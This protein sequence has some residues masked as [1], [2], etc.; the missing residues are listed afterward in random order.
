MSQ[1]RREF[2]YNL[3]GLFV[4]G[5][6]LYDKLGSRAIFGT[7]KTITPE[8]KGTPLSDLSPSSKNHQIS[9]I[10]DI[11]NIAMRWE[12]L[13]DTMML[14]TFE[15]PTESLEETAR[16]FVRNPLRV[17]DDSVDKTIV[18]NLS[19]DFEKIFTTNNLQN[20]TPYPTTKKILRSGP[21]GEFCTDEQKNIECI[22]KDKGSVTKQEK[23][24]PDFTPRGRRPVTVMKDDRKLPQELELIPEIVRFVQSLE[25]KRDYKRDGMLL[26]YSQYPS[27]TLY[28]GIGDCED[29][30]ILLA[31]FLENLQTVDIRTALAFPPGHAATLAAIPDLPNSKKYTEYTTIEG[32]PYT[33]LETT[34]TSEIYGTPDSFDSIESLFVYH[35]NSIKNINLHILPA[36]ARK[37]LQILKQATLEQIP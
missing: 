8:L 29:T 36:T 9:K 25:Y 6:L 1:K 15:L 26:D 20:K 27:E 32:V 31:T 3:S 5:G 10:D 17:F 13:D 14:Y 21:L 22:E 28:M 33:F 24:E 11:Y 23:E 30:A 37:G 19:R 7:S 16:P 12:R 34:D 4:G 35:N 18:R 2:L